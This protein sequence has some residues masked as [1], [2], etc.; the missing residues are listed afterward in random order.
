[1]EY[2]IITTQP[3]S[4]DAI[5]A[6][7]THWLRGGSHRPGIGHTGYP[8][9]P[10]RPASLLQ[11]NQ[12]NTAR[13][14][15]GVTARMPSPFETALRSA[16]TASPFDSHQLQTTGEIA[17]GPTLHLRQTGQMG[18]RMLHYFVL[19][20]YDMLVMEQASLHARW[21]RLPANWNRQISYA[22]IG[23]QVSIQPVLATRLDVAHMSEGEK[24]WEAIKRGTAQLPQES[25]ELVRSIFT[26]TGIAIMLLIAA[27]VVLGG[28]LV[29]LGAV[30]FGASLGLWD[31]VTN[32]FDKVRRFYTTAVNA[33]T[34][35]DLDRAGE[36]LAEAVLAGG[37]DVLDIFCAPAALG[38][39]RAL[40]RGGTISPRVIWA[41]IEE[42]YQLLT[43]RRGGGGGRVTNRPRGADAPP[44]NM[45]NSR[46]G[47][48]G[49][50]VS[51]R[52][53]A[54]QGYTKLNDGGQ[55]TRSTDPARGTGI[56]GV[57]RNPNYPPNPEYII[58]EAKYGSSQLGTSADGKQ[59][60]DSWIRGS[61]RLERATG[62][63]Q[64]ADAISDAMRRPGRV[65][66][67]IHRID[68]QGNITVH[69]VGRNG[70]VGRQLH[71]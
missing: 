32:V 49:E 52:Y 59:M 65:Q 35:Q 23:A 63:R 6:A 61:N 2:R 13:P 22:T 5:V 33:R 31:L 30:I 9:Q 42:R 19:N 36:L 34:E 18:Y 55:L 25:A 69:E 4:H 56:D 66:K 51:D 70:D 48:Y 64:Q 17:I 24:L 53:M 62:S 58:T 71:P 45:S 60:S 68:E 16:P 43:A 29:A 12:F 39:L 47:V 67:Q 57:W 3:T 14:G 26:P 15:V 38:R 41:F 40:A 27:A 44:A 28:E 20:N 21:V 37:L 8:Q 50:H 11:T 10:F 46:K 7:V 54:N 1:M